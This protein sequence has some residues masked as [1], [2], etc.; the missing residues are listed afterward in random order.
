MTLDGK[1]PRL[2]LASAS[3]RRIELLRM[4]GAK[5]SVLPSKIDED[6]DPSMPAAKLV[7]RNA[8]AK[9]TDVARRLDSG[10]VIGADTIVVLEGKI[11]G[12]PSDLEDARRMLS[13][14]AGNTHQVYSGLAVVRVE[15][16]TCKTAHAV[17]QVTFRPLSEQQ[18][19]K[20]FE[21]IDPLDKAGAYAIQGI[22][23]VIIE[24]IAGCYYNVVGLPLTVLDNLLS[25]FGARLL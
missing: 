21:M 19:T 12:K 2:V 1:K 10:L 15:D 23:G 7:E 8:L 18:I 25:Y 14:L 16:G 17:T 4:L 24:K 13:A 9:A 6:S 5:P 22:G 11:F 3:P 20:Y